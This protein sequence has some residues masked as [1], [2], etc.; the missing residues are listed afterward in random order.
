MKKRFI[1]LSIFTAIVV[2]VLVV[3]G[4]QTYQKRALVE[5]QGKES[6]ANQSTEE[7]AQRELE[8]G[9][10]FYEKLKNG[11]DVNILVVGNSMAL[12]EGASPGF[13]WIYM[14]SEE[15]KNKYHSDVRYKSI[16]SAYSRYESGIVKLSMLDNIS[17]YDAVII[18]YSPTELEDEL[19]QY[20]AILRYVKKYNSNIAII[21]ILANSGS[22]ISS[23]KTVA[24]TDHYGGI[25]VDMQNLINKEGSG[26]LDHDFYPNDEGYKLYAK[27]TFESICRTVAEGKTNQVDSVNAMYEDV[28]KYNNC[29]FVPMS[30]CQKPDS[31]SFIVDINNFNGEICLLTHFNK[32][33]QV[34]DIYFDGGTWLLQNELSYSA[35]C[36]YDSFIFH[37]MPHIKNEVVFKLSGDS[38][39]DQ[40]LG[41]CF[42]SQDA[43]T[44]DQVE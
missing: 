43:I 5:N 23:S 25:S 21:S 24:L 39:L 28:K 34:Y 20:E 11:F 40:F 42:I 6:A 27:A 19:I 8:Q 38:T 31:N 14:L 17:V 41:I 29:V 13:D 1:V 12:S 10:N 44:F 32:G 2:I 16:A 3:L 35:D 33:K 22:L 7:Q 30:R 37:D 9:S 18:C 26:V 36:W 15:L 4:F